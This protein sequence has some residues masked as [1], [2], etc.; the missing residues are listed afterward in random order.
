MKSAKQIQDHLRHVPFFRDLD[1]TELAR[2]AGAARFRK[3]ERGAY[4]F[5]EGDPARTLYVLAEG[6]VRLNQAS[7]EGQQVLLRFVSAGEPFG[8]IGSLG[9]TQYPASAEV[10][11]DSLA[12]YWDTDTMAELME[13]HPPLA[14]AALRMLARQ[15]Q[16]MQ[17]RYRELATERVERRLARSLLRLSAQTGRQVPGGILL[18]VRLSRQDLAEM[19]GT[20]LYTV[21]RILSRWEQAGLVKSRR[22]R[23]LIRRPEGLVAVAEDTSP[24]PAVDDGEFAAGNAT[25]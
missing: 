6:R 16:E 18:D 9:S 1:E 12:L 23:V 4:F 19:T 14:M 7:T 2:V 25:G 15:V 24:A 13:R 21:S 5:H 20:T 8:W 3:L 10:V 11:E 22:E 17:E